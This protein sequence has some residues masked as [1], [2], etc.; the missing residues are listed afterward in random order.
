MS[1][2]IL[3]TDTLS[4]IQQSNRT[5]LSAL[6]A[7]RAAGDTVAITTVTVREQWRLVS[8]IPQART[9]AQ[10]AALRKCSHCHT[11]GRTHRL[12]QTDLLSAPYALVAMKLNV[13]KMDRIASVLSNLERD[14]AHNLRDFG[15]IPG[16]LVVDSTVPPPPPA[17][18]TGAP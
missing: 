16:L 13:G 1:L 3:D 17:S 11:L 8:G 6:V 12:P 9:H 18:P 14:R 4:L 2:F 5:V 10:R 15:R 7:A